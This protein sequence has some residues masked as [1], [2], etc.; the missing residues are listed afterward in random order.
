[1]EIK[2][3][4]YPRGRVNYEKLVKYILNPPKPLLTKKNERY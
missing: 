4:Q 2:I 1:M 3:N